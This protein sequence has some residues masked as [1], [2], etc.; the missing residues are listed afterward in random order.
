MEVLLIRVSL[1]LQMLS[2]P[3]L[4]PQIIGEEWT[5]SANT[6]KL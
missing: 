1:G 4:T 5:R 2:L 3:L 6:S